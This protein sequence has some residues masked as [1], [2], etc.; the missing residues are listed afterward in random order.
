MENYELLKVID[1][2]EGNNVLYLK[3]YNL[4]KGFEKFQN[5]LFLFYKCTRR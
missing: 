1:I 3:I 2:W 4:N 5:L